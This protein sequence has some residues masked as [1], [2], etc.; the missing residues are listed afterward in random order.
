MQLCFQ[1]LFGIDGKDVRQP[2][3]NIG[4]QFHASVQ[5]FGQRRAG[6]AQ[7]IGR[8]TYR[9]GPWLQA[10]FSDPLTDNAIFIDGHTLLPAFRCVICCVTRYLYVIQLLLF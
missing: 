5:N 4:A 3:C 10:M 6:N 9:Q 8:G 7:Q 2:S 1:Q